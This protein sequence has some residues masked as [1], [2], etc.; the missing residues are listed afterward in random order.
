LIDALDALLGDAG[1][2]A[3]WWPLVDR[4]LQL[5]LGREGQAGDIGQPDLGRRADPGLAKLA[6]VKRRPFREVLELSVPS[7][8]RLPPTDQPLTRFRRPGPTSSLDR[9]SRP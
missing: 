3:E 5:V 6:G 7:R 8:S 9:R 2:R 1:I 4:L